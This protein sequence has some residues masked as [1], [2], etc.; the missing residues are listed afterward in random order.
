MKE[1][2]ISY[3]KY[4]KQEGITTSG[5]GYRKRIG[6][7]KT[8]KVGKFTYVVLNGAEE[9]QA[10]TREVT[11]EIEAVCETLRERIKMLESQIEEK[12][13]EMDR[14]SKALSVLA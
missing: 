9:K 3:A 12:Q 4:A 2:L 10:S 14:I 1:S 7:I 13:H 8:R 11:S 6:Q 5:V